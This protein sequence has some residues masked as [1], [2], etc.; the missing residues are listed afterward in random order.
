SA[1]KRCPQAATPTELPRVR[2]MHYK[3]HLEFHPGSWDDDDV[4][5]REVYGLSMEEM[6]ASSNS[7]RV[8]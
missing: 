3:L 2:T 4:S 7:Y 5:C 1:W 8:A 6:S